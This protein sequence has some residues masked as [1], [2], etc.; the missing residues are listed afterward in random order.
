MEDSESKI[1]VAEPKKQRENFI[2]E[3]WPKHRRSRADGTCQ[4]VF[5][6]Q[7]TEETWRI[8]VLEQQERTGILIHYLFEGQ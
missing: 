6:P 1:S 5:I 8:D 2:E 7:G 4:T 3:E